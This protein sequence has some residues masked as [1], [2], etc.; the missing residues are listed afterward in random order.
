MQTIGI[1][2]THLASTL[3]LLM[4]K[5][6]QL[7]ATIR[8]SKAYVQ[9][10]LRVGQWLAYLV[11][12][13]VL[14]VLRYPLAPVAVRFFSRPDKRRLVTWLEPL[15]TLDNDLD[16][17]SGWRNEHIKPGSDPLSDSNRI[18]WL[19][20][21]GFNTANFTWLGCQGDLLWTLVRMAQQHQRAFWYRDDG[22]WMLRTFIPFPDVVIFDKGRLCWTPT[23]RYLNVYWG[24]SLFGTVD[25]RHKFTFTTRVKSTRP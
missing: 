12:H 6:L 15:M 9:L 17:D 18:K 25:G 1:L 24:W 22:Y 19:W 16:G 5:V 10:G 23:E 8:R 2:L 4:H 13:L 3:L 20:R 21:N 14:V 7:Y 11:A